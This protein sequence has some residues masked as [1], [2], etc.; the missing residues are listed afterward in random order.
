VFFY[1]KVRRK[2]IHQEKT[3]TSQL[4]WHSGETS[5]LYR[6]SQKILKNEK[7]MCK[8]GGQTK[9]LKKEEKV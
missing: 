6:Q 2:D 1:G 8:R 9:T 5:I 7:I 4:S 3:T